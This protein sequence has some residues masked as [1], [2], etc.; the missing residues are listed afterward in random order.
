VRNFGR[1][2]SS[3]RVCTYFLMKYAL[4]FDNVDT[5]MLGSSFAGYSSND[6]HASWKHQTVKTVGH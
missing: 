2:L 5:K 1:S 6:A 4:S 3:F